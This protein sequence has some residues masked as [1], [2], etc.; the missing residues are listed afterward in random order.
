MKLLRY[1]FI[2]VF[3]IERINAQLVAWIDPADDTVFLCQNNTVTL[4]GF[5]NGG[6]PPYT[7]Y[8]TGHIGF[9]DNPNA[10]TVVFTG[11][12]PGNYRLWFNVIDGNND[13]AKDS[14]VIVVKPKPI[15]SIT[16]PT[17]ICQGQT[18]TLIASGA[19]TYF[20]FN[21]SGMLIGIGS[22]FQVSPTTTTCLLYTS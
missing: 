3:M 15:L 22:P 4:H 6:I 14:I 1:L 13:R 9:L 19:T 8:W 16:G 12:T 7:F 2:L 18:A 11:S 17:V 10:Q 21:E 20:W 5:F